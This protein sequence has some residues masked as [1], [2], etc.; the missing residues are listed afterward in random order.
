MKFQHILVKLI[1][2]TLP[3]KNFNALNSQSDKGNDYRSRL[4][5]V[6]GR[7][8]RI[9][10]S[11]SLLLF[12]FLFRTHYSLTHS[13]G[14]SLFQRLLPARRGVPLPLTKIQTCRRSTFRLQSVQ[15]HVPPALLS[16]TQ[17]TA[18]KRAIRLGSRGKL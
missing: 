10:Y 11:F 13:P 17:S 16:R 8:Q 5:A 2:P 18:T 12:L 14:S 7:G 6:T 9:L 15:T 4:F 3:G 1:Y